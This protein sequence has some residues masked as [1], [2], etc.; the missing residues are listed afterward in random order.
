MAETKTARITKRVVD[1]VPP[2]SSGETR[3]WDREIKGFFLRVYPTGRRVYA[4]KY[5]QGAAQRILTIGTHGSPWSPDSARD[6]A[7]DAMEAVHRGEDPAAEKKAVR[8]ALTVKEM[9]DS[10]LTDGPATKPAKR[11]S[12]W[13]D[14]ASNLRRHIEPLLGRRPAALVSAEEA[15]KAISD[16][17]AGKTAAAAIKSGAKRGRIV[18]T[19]GEGVARRT[20]LTAAAMFAWGLDNGRI[21]GGNP[22][23][24]VKLTA[25]PTRERF[26]SRD[27]ALRLF[28]ALTDLEGE[29]KINP[30]F[31]DTIRLLLLTG[32]RKTEILGLRWS[33]VDWERNR[34]QLPPARTKAGGKTGARRIV[35]SPPAVEIL[36]R[37]HRLRHEQDAFVFPANSKSGHAIAAR[38][39]FLAACKQAGLSG[40]RV[41]D[42]RH[43]FASF[44]VAEG[45][46]LF[47]VGKLLGHA[48]TRTTER[49][50]HLS[51]DP[52][53]VAA[54]AIGQAL[55]GTPIKR[56]APRSAQH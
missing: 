53:Q 29:G 31:A 8:T 41:H 21:Q 30:M 32:A 51:A 48:S 39:P 35:L 43:S 42:L 12:T 22:F 52:L 55:S 28:A 18:V 25:P 2:P 3:V 1:A 15:A 16:I 45:A 17:A 6:R 11:L 46:S 7:R 13:T 54:A 49:Y 19:G 50:A 10:Y 38:R 24:K 47:L 34:I 5:R 4:M 44:A 36:R 40:V 14:D 20:R 33:E 27:E 23:S 37:R 26:L 9:I 56:P